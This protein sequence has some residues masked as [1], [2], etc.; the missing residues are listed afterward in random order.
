MPL[1]FAVTLFVSASLLFMVQPMVGKMVLPLLGGSPAVWNAC[2]VFFQ[3]LLL[4]GYLYAHKLSDIQ[5]PRKQW[6]IHLLVLAL[7]LAVFAAAAVFSARHTPIAILEALAPTDE[8]SPIISVLLILTVAIG[9]PFFVISTTATLLQKWFVFTGHPSAR[10]PY[11]LYSASNFGSLISLLG[12]PLLI[13]P[14]MTIPAQAWVFASGFALLVGLIYFC[15][16]AAANPIGVPPGPQS[17]GGK[18]AATVVDPNTP[19]PAAPPAEVP[20]L[21]RKLKWVVL[22]FVPSTL[23]L[24]VTFHMTT[25][26][27]SV[28]LLWVAPLALYL[29]TFIIAFGRVPDWFR[30]VI[31]NLA[32]VMILLLVFVLISGVDPGYGVKIIL[33]IL[34]F[35]AAALMCHYELARDRPAPQ[36]LT[37]FF[38]L[39]SLGG[40]LGGTFNALVAPL[41]FPHPYEYPIALIIACLMVPKLLEADKDAPP[42]E[43]EPMPRNA[44]EAVTQ[45]GPFVWAVANVG[46]IAAALLGLFWRS[47]KGFNLLG[48]G[49]PTLGAM[50]T[51]YVIAGMLL[52]GVVSA[53]G[54]E[55]YGRWKLKRPGLTRDIWDRLPMA[56][57]VALLILVN[58]LAVPWATAAVLHTGP[59]LSRYLD[60]VIPIG[61]GLGFYALCHLPGMDWYIETCESIAKTVGLSKQTVVVVVLYAVP[62]MLC[63]FFV[64][65]PLRFTLCVAAILGPLTI[66]ESNQG[67]VHSERSFFGILKISESRYG[68]PW[69]HGEYTTEDELGKPVKRHNIIKDPATGNPVIMMEYLMRQLHHGTT[70]HGTQFGYV[71]D[72]PGKASGKLRSRHPRDD[73]QMISPDISAWG[74]F[75]TIATTHAYDIRE[76][77]LTYYH[78][79]GPVGAMFAELWRRKGGADGK[80]PFAM[81]GLGTGSVSCYA[82]QGQNITFYEIDPAVKHLVADTDKYFSYVTDAKKRGANLDLRM[83]DARLKLKE[84]TDQ[85][86]AL[87][88]VDAFSSDSIP[89]HLLTVEAVKLY[90]ERMTDDGM[91]ALHIS[92]RW[93]NLEPVVAS[94]A[95][96]LGLTARVWN[97]NSEGR[98]G[99]TASSWVILARDP[100]HLGGLYSPTGDLVFSGGPKPPGQ[101]DVMRFGRAGMDY[102]IT[103]LLTREF[104]ELQVEGSIKGKS[105][106]TEMDELPAEQVK[107]AWEKWTKEKID[108]TTDPAT[109]ERL[110]KY[111]DLMTRYK[112]HI[113]IQEAMIYDHGH[114][115]RRLETMSQVHPWTD[116]FSD[117]MRVMTIPEVQRVR[118]FFGLPS[119]MRRNPG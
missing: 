11:F 68:G 105:K 49:Q 5:N 12:Y 95:N 97:D 3:A 75:A 96:E 21:G 88:L 69:A 48:E 118:E 76:E 61:V 10:D 98:R 24:G 72:E 85:K 112:P 77:P 26:I 62:V 28:P 2:M 113:T 7:P 20:T 36:Y 119:P 107:S 43:S 27:A 89:V 19:L 33:H 91:L 31:G 65:R 99:K 80:A 74:M 40:V 22:A 109:K 30:M 101:D 100:K 46:L 110:T 41:I 67:L 83:G 47:P 42:E 4:L 66:R 117:V 8:R 106:A 35:F 86:Y 58:P 82:R 38:L 56:A 34:T 92:N 79:T 73:F 14:R 6:M 55:V 39:M 29:I 64:D 44:T 60:L 84:A 93:L 87:L 50:T 114:A 102:Q 111:L 23:M 45:W 94:I 81:V 90:L 116:D 32:P 54:V 59:R 57:K 37:G 104:Q 78:Q 63:F 71:E 17:G 15:G 13:E 51:L 16:R 25:D 9:I 18:K 108:S 1:L 52:L 115:F 70:L 53:V 103:Q